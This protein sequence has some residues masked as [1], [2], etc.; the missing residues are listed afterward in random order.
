MSF[1]EE[2]KRRNV[3]RVGIAYAVVGWLLIEVSSVILPTFNAPEWVMRVFVMFV[4]FGFP[5]A[6]ISPGLLSAPLKV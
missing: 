4:M 5:L 2:L 1:F 3:F 6:L